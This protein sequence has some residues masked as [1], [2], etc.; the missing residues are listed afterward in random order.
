M[1]PI[2]PL[3]APR[4]MAGTSRLPPS[5][6]ATGLLLRRDAHR[7]RALRRPHGAGRGRG[8]PPHPHGRR[9]PRPAALL[10]GQLLRAQGAPGDA[11]AAAS[12]PV[13]R[14]GC[15]RPA[16]GHFL[17]RRGVRRGGLPFE[18][19]P[20][21]GRR[22]LGRGGRA[23]AVLVF[24]GAMGGLYPLTWTTD[25]VFSFRGFMCWVDYHHGILYCDVFSDLPELRFVQLPGIEIWD[26][27]HDYSYGRQMPVA[28]K[29]VEVS[30]G[31]IKFVDVDNGQFG[32]KKSSGFCITSWTL[33]TPELEWEKDGDV[34]QVDDLWSLEE[35]RDSPL[36]RWVPEFPVVSKHDS[37][38]VHFVLRGP[39]SGAKAWVISVGT[40]PKLLKSYMPYKNDYTNLWKEE[41]DLDLTSLFFDTPFICSDLYK[42]HGMSV[43]QMAGLAATT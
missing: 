29:T 15:P 3:S 8:P 10:P 25:K 34:L 39:R 35:F 19:H 16:H 21:R 6:R 18:H 2:P 26:D 41:E 32:V 28:Y 4:A 20:R 17:P 14:L 43:G 33:R 12:P 1:S 9:H 11:V 37:D 22:E 13:R 24:H 30:N 36:P 42:D 27:S 38:V 23:L 40:R 31:V 5:C 7:C